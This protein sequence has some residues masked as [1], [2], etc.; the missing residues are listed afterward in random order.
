MGHLEEKIAAPE[1][2]ATAI[3]AIVATG[4]ADSIATSAINLPGKVNNAVH[5]HFDFSRKIAQFWN[6][7]PRK[8]VD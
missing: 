6:I 5:T 8:N 4:P 1:A 2:T 7:F 3:T